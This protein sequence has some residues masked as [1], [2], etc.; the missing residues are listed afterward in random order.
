MYAETDPG[1]TVG[2]G[3][4]KQHTSTQRIRRCIPPSAGTTVAEPEEGI[5][6][7][8]VTYAHILYQ[9]SVAVSYGAHAYLYLLAD[10]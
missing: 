3:V 6:D 5:L 8:A 9:T 1:T 2:E 10:V 4:Y 7:K